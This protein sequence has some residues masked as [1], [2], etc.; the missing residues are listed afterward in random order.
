MMFVS[1]AFIFLFG[2]ASASKSKYC[3][4][5]SQSN[6][7]SNFLYPVDIY[8][9]KSGSH[10]ASDFD[11]VNCYSIHEAR[12]MPHEFQN[13]HNCSFEYQMPCPIY[14]ELMVD[15]VKRM[16]AISPYSPICH[17]KDRLNSQSEVFN[18]YFIGGSV[19]GMHHIPSCIYIVTC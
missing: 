6:F 15:A 17:L 7:E 19:T 5:T 9:C 14:P 11:T 2:H 10:Y 13:R 4:V 1:Y 18:V 3:P 12:G 8:D 16:K